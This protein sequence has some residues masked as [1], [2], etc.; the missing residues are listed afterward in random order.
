MDTE[1]LSSVDQVTAHFFLGLA[2]MA[3]LGSG[4]AFLPWPCL[5]GAARLCD[6]ICTDVFFFFLSGRIVRREDF[7][8]VASSLLLFYLQQ[9][10]GYRPECH[11]PALFSG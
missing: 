6:G 11:R 5:D 1:G 4:M 2:L 7:Q 8:P 9:C 10:R 3:R